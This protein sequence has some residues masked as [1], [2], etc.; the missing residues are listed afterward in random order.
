M[1]NSYLVAL[2]EI[3]LEALSLIKVCRI[4]AYSLLAEGCSIK[5]SSTRS[6]RLSK[7]YRLCYWCCKNQHGFL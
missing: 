5:F 2:Y 1:P 4:S 6:D 3:K 7:R